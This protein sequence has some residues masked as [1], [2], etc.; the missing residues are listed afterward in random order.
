MPSATE[1]DLFQSS[2]M[3]FGEHLEELRGCL[4]RAAAGLM[5]GVVVGFSLLGRWFG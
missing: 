5:L 4:I 1:D 2:T 3:T